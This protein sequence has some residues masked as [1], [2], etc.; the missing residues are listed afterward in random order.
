MI[1]YKELAEIKYII[2]HRM[3]GSHK[4]DIEYIVHLDIE[5][6]EMMAGIKE[7]MNTLI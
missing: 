5:F 1:L 7:E 4:Y 6:S 3:S 2:N